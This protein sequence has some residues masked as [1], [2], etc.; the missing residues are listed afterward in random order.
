MFAP[1]NIFFLRLTQYN[2]NAQHARTL[3]PYEYTYANPTRTSTFEGQSTDRSG[4]S[5]SHHW[6][7]VVDRNVAYHLAYNA[8]KSRNK[9]RK[10]CEHQDLNPSGSVPLDRPTIGLQAQSP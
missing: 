6:R 3:T 1:E 4:D 10:R 9:S 2:A 7:L 8:E 5:R